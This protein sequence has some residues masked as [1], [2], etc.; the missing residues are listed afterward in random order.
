VEDALVFLSD[1]ISHIKVTEGFRNVLEDRQ[2]DEVD[3]AAINLSATVTEYL[4]MAIEYFTDKTLGKNLLSQFLSFV[5]S[6]TTNLVQHVLPTLELGLLG[7][8]NSRIRRA[9]TILVL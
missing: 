2:L 6:G 8:L 3:C 1:A 7:V 4:A 5:F 9:A